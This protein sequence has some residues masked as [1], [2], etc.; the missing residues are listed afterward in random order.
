MYCVYTFLLPAINETYLQQ[1]WTC[2]Y[3]LAARQSVDKSPEDMVDLAKLAEGGS[4]RTFLIRYPAMVPKYLV[5][6]SKLATMTF[7]RSFGLPIPKVSISSMLDNATET[8]E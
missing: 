5:V 7:L 4:D 3:R 2:V 6:A 1:V 8:A